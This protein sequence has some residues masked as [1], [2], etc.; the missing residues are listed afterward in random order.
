MNK[1]DAIYENLA[2]NVGFMGNPE[3]PQT[4][5]GIN[6]DSSASQNIFTPN[7]Y[8]VS[9]NEE[10]NK[11]NELRSALKKIKDILDNIKL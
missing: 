11:N 2:K 9:E 3:T 4:S 8:R 5:L 7:E 1:F 10:E 6:Q